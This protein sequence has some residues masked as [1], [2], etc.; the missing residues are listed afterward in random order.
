VSGRD[1]PPAVCYSDSEI[2]TKNRSPRGLTVETL[3]V[4][5]AIYGFLQSFI[6][7]SLGRG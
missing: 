1:K 6:K 5:A 2:L 7:A 4:T 3:I